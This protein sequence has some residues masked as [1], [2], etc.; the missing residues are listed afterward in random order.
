ML[1]LSSFPH[2]V[3][4]PDLF[5]SILEHVH[6]CAESWCFAGQADLG[7]GFTVQELESTEGLG[8]SSFVDRSMKISL[9]A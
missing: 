8:L 2:L 6:S 3:T 1:V 7:N 9:I 4:V 5:P